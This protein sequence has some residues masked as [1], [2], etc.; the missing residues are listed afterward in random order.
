MTAR[1]TAERHP[2]IPPQL[3][4]HSFRISPASSPIPDFA[5]RRSDAG[6]VGCNRAATAQ[7]NHPSSNVIGNELRRALL[8][9]DMNGESSGIR[10]FRFL[11]ATD[12]PC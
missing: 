12:N 11:K 2:L 4:S 5:G 7:P 9:R 8:S 10:R 6:L 1:T 3:A